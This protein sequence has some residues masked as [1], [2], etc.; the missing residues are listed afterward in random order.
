MRRHEAHPLAIAAAIALLAASIPVPLGAQ[1]DAERGTARPPGWL[2]TIDYLGR[3]PEYVAIT[4]ADR[5]AARARLQAIERLLR[6]LPV[7]AP[8]TGFEVQA[9][10][11]WKTLG[12]REL[13]SGKTVAS[14]ALSMSVFTPTRAIDGETGTHLTITVNPSVEDIAYESVVL[15]AG[16]DIWIEH[17][18]L[19]PEEEPIHDRRL[20]LAVYTPYYAFDART[21]LPFVPALGNVMLTPAGFAPWLPV[22]KD[23]FLR[24]VI[25]ST[26]GS[27]KVAWR[28]HLDT[29]NMTP[30]D[31]WLG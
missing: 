25:E 27:D 16:T 31:I 29:L 7:L 21:D 5:A 3:T 9:Q 26:E 14:Y 28:A 15:D 8:L 12:T 1:R 17:T 2:P 30:L 13:A 6:S 19:G 18:R 24:M 10:F 22:P 4:P 20:D 23:L 11:N